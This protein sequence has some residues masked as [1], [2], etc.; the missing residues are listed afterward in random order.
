MKT[1][2]AFK[3]QP[4]P[5]VV[6]SVQI[7]IEQEIPST[8]SGIQQQDFACDK[9]AQAIE[10][11]LYGALPGGVYDR[12]LGWMLQRKASHFRVTYEAK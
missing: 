2:H 11:A 9:N 6:P 5:D 3:A 7:L 12:L 8:F 4:S 1:V 10:S